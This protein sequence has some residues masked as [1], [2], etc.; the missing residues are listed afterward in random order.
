MSSLANIIWLDTVAME[1][2]VDTS[3]HPRI[4]RRK[5]STFGGVY[6]IRF[7]PCITEYTAQHEVFTDFGGNVAF[8]KKRSSFI[9]NLNGSSFR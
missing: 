8:S 2:G 1:C 6:D 3:M 5:V 4:W 7:E 9:P